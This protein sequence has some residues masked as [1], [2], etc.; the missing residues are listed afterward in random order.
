M[1]NTKRKILATAKS[2]FNDLGYSN[3]TIRMIALELQMSSGNLNYH[4]KTREDILE[5]LY[6]EMVEE[7]DNRLKQLGEQEITFESIKKDMYHSLK[8]MIE[9]RFIWTDLYNLLRLNK[10]IKKHFDAV[11]TQRFEGYEFLIKYLNNKGLLKAFEYAN[12]RQLLIE[13]MIGFSDTWLYNSFIY[14]IEID[15]DYIN[16]QTNNLL[17]MIYPYLTDMGKDEFQKIYT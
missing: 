6:F 4:F 11:Y 17:A 3:V 10:V 9:Y 14:E 15:D 7:F 12:E 2:L 13:R 8:R 1:K 16:H 5:A